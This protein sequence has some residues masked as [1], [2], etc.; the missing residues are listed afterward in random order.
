MA[1]KKILVIDDNA[2]YR[3]TMGVF[4]AR[5]GFEVI[6]AENGEIGWKMI[7]EQH[8]DLVLLDVMMEILF[9]GFE[10]CR[11]VRTDPEVKHIPIIGISGMGNEIGVKFDQVADQEY[12]S[13]DEYMEKPVDKDAL[14]QKIKAL[15][16]M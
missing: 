16:R 3:F 1:K 10:V 2:D 15:L 5:N 11:R 6:N 8:P 12:F 4:L 13:P 14:L 9:S 7:K